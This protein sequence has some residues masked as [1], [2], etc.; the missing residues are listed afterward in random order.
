MAAL[1]FIAG[2]AGAVTPSIS[3]FQLDNGAQFTK[4]TVLNVSLIESD[5]ANMR[6]S[7]DANHYSALQSYASSATFSMDSSLGCPTADGTA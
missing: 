5:A 1:L 2:F 3:S 6:F 7:C 4:S